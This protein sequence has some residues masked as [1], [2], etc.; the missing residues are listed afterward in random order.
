MYNPATQQREMLL[1]DTEQEVKLGQNMDSQ[2]HQKMKFVTEHYQVQ[3]LQQ[4]GQRIAQVSDRQDLTYQF[5]IVDDKTLNAFAIP[6]G[7]VYIHKGLMDAANDDELAAVIAHEIG[8]IAARHSVKQI[9]AVL[10]Y[11][12]VLSIVTGGRTNSSA[13]N[14]ALS[15]VFELVNLGYSRKDEF[16]ADKLAV[17]YTR[18]AG[19]SPLGIITLF[20]KLE[21]EKKKSPNLNLVF[22]SSHPP[23]T[24]RIARVEEQ[25]RQPLD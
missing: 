24:E 12:L 17:R 13:L 23:I 5:A 6:G 14:D 8:H 11:Q 7:Y 20:Q 3:R 15:V 21:S 1:I 9:Q 19:Y 2:L 16:L 10:G 4:I 25:M 22:L 18:R